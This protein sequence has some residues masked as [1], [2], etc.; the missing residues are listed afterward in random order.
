MT[1]RNQNVDLS[2]KVAEAEA[3]VAGVKDAELRRIAFEKVLD[4]L[5]S[6]GGGS[7]PARAGDDDAETRPSRAER[8][9]R[10]SASGGKGLS[11]PKAL[12]EQMI[13]DGFFS[14]PRTIS[15]VRSEMANQGYHIPRTSLSG[16]LRLLTRE[17]KLRRSKA[18][19][20]GSAKGV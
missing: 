7:H 14:T 20:D 1:T 16:P 3:A 4:R 17:R 10:G 13:E 18:V 9:T 8:K 19:Q 11:G 2:A 6:A 15:D 5:L 12:I